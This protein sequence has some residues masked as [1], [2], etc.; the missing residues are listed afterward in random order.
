VS[1]RVG[2]VHE[3]VV[4]DDLK[5]TQIVMYAGASGDFNPVHSDE[6]FAKAIGMPGVFA[7]GMLTMG[8]SGTALTRFVGHGT[9][10]AWAAQLRRQVWP[11]DTLTTRCEV[12]AERVEHGERL[13]DVVVTT[14][15]Q[16][17][18]VVLTGTATARADG[19]GA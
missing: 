3:Q 19:G 6:R 18:D 13:V 4:V 2:D 7:H 1:L 17:G 14:T 16:D 5:R 8:M 10:T 11:G 15:N 12:V 9:L